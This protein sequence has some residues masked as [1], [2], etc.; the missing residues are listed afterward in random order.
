M[1]SGVD[2]VVCRPRLPLKDLAVRAGAGAG[3]SVVGDSR[4]ATWAAASRAKETAK[5][6]HSRT[7]SATTAAARRVTFP[8][9][10]T[11]GSG[12]GDGESKKA[13]VALS[14]SPKRD[15][16]NLLSSVSACQI[17]SVFMF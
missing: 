6:A 3:P 13:K 11:L 8:R 2:A 7:P 14:L 4:G 16:A 5:A 15:D 12:R 9:R 1:I 17:S 10:E